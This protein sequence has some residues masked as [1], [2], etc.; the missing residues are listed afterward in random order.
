MTR[1]V[2]LLRAYKSERARLTTSQW[3][4]PGEVGAGRD[5][6][7]QSLLEKSVSV[8]AILISGRGARVQ[9]K[10]RVTIIAKVAK[11]PAVAPPMSPR[12]PSAT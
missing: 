9:G 5:Y 12:A 4:P 10:A 11:V 8:S 2:Y 7:F 3:S 1:L 6:P